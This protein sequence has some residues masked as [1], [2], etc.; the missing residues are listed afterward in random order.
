MLIIEFQLE[1]IKDINVGIVTHL[2]KN[3]YQEF[4]CR[5]YLL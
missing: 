1:T 3:L 5:I 2:F 4:W